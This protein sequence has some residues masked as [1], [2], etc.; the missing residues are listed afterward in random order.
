MIDSECPHTYPDSLC[1][2]AFTDYV[3]TLWRNRAPA[4]ASALVHGLMPHLAKT[5]CHDLVVRWQAAGQL[6]LGMASFKRPRAKPSRAL[7]VATPED[8]V[9]LVLRCRAEC[10]EP[11]RAGF[12]AA[13]EARTK[14]ALA[15]STGAWG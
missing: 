10:A 13:I 2:A 5:N 1:H 7:A 6:R 15:D 4:Q 8:L 11:H 3:A 14:A 9:A 12:L